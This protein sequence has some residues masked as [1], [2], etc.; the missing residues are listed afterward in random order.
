MGLRG[1]TRRRS[2]AWPVHVLVI[3]GLVAL[4]WGCGATLGATFW[5]SFDECPGYYGSE[6]T[7]TAPGTLRGR[8]ICG[9]GDSAS[10]WMLLWSLV[11]LMLLIVALLLW[12]VR[13]SLRV[14]VPV[15]VAAPLIVLAP[16]LPVSQLPVECSQEQWRDLGPEGCE[17]DL[18]NRH[19]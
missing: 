19:F 4:W 15:V 1:M 5:V 3:V 17:R 14:L 13:T 11:P 2:Y 9:D 6:G 8:I 16:I 7:I 12:F 18:E 10:P